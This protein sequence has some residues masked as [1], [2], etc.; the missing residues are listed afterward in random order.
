MPSMQVST[1]PSGVFNSC[2][3]PEANTPSDA[4]RWDSARFASAARRSEMSRHTSTTCVR[5]PLA[6]RIGDT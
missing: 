5:R 3:K 6:S 1:V 2:E 4:R